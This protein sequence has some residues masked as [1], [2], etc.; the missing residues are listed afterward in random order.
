MTVQEL[1]S[2]AAEAATVRKTAPRQALSRAARLNLIDQLS[3]WGGS[4][5]AL[6]AGVSIFIVIV[7]ARGMP[8]RSAIWA[9][10]IFVSLYLCRRYRKGFRRGDHIASRPFRWRAYY[11]ATL[12][13][14]SAA[15]GAGAF[16][17]L[18]ESVSP[19]GVMQTLAL[20]L[21]AVT[22]AAAFHLAHRPSAAA[23]GLPAFA[24]IAGAAAANFGPAPFTLG[25]LAT[26]LA[27]AAFVF[28]ASAEAQR[29]AAARFPRTTFV[30]REL[31]DRPYGEA[32][33]VAT[34]AAS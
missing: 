30:R 16:L 7:I 8:L 31:E 22:G 29:R 33:P 3:R 34:R 23:A 13:V 4:G 18:P 5:L 21:V 2:M 17:I 6:F 19:G 12:A 28:F 10:M 11:T 14:V 15:F 27:A 1:Q 9:A 32:Q 24:A 26:G 25:V 20:M